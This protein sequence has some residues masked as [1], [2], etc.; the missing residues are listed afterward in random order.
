[1]RMTLSSRALAAMAPILAGLPHVVTADFGSCRP[2]WL[3]GECPC[4]GMEPCPDA[5]GTECEA[6]GEGV[7]IC[8]RCVRNRHMDDGVRELMLCALLP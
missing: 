3:A 4:C 7:I 2:R 5:D 1:M 8:G 6:I